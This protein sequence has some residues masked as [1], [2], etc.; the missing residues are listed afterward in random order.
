MSKLRS[1]FARSTSAVAGNSKTW[2]HK[3]RRLIGL[4]LFAIFCAVLLMVALVPPSVS[5]QGG[6]I[7]PRGGVVAESTPSPLTAPLKVEPA[8]L[9]ELLTE[10]G[11]R[12]FLVYLRGEPLSLRPAAKRTVSSTAAVVEAL[13]SR[14]ERSFATLAP[15]VE[16]LSREGHLRESHLLWLPNALAVS[17]DLHALQSLASRPE[18]RLIRADRVIRINEDDAAPTL[19][20]PGEITWNISRIQADRAWNA[21]GITGEGV[22]VA[23]V[24]TG[25]DWLHPALQEAYRGYDPK[26][27]HRH[28]GNWYDATGEGA[29]YPVDA[30]GHGTHVMGIIVGQDGIGVA[31]GAK[32]IAVRAFNSQ[33]LGYASWIHRAFEWILAPEGDPSLAPDVVNNSWGS[34]STGSQEFREDLRAL[35]AAGILPV[36]AAGNSGPYSRTVDSPASLPEALAVGATDADDEVA[37]FS[38]RGPSPWGEVKPEVAAP[39]V[40][41]LSAIPGGA[42]GTKSGTS[43]AAPHAAGVVAL[44]LQADPS[45]TITETEGILTRTATPLGEQTPNNDAGWGL[46]NAYRAAVVASSAGFVSGTVRGE[47]GRPIAWARVTAT[48]YEGGVPVATDVSSDGRYSIALAAGDYALEVTAFGYEPE[49]VSRVRVITGQASV[50]DFSL[51]PLPR[52]YVR[53]TVYE[54]GTG[55]PLSATVRVLDTPVAAATDPD[56]GGYSLELPTGTYTFGVYAWEHRI[57]LARNVPVTA[58]QA[59]TLDF[60][61]EPAPSILVVD[62]GAWYYGSQIHYFEDALNALGYPYHLIRIKNPYED[63]PVFTT[64]M[65]YD[66]V[67]W[68][69]PLDSPG[70]VGAWGA[71]AAYLN[72]GGRLFLTGQDVAFWDDGGSGTFYAPELREYTKAKLA[73]DES[74][75]RGIVGIEGTLFDGLSFDIAGGDGADNQLYP[76]AIEVAEPDFAVL[77]LRYD[78][79][80]IAAVGAFRCL[81]YRSVFFSF[82][83][84]AIAGR[85]ARIQVMD[86]VLEWLMQPDPAEG[87]E[88]ISPRQTA[89][90]EAGTSVSLTLRIRNIGEAGT[91]ETYTLSVE[92]ADWPTQLSLSSVTLAPCVSATF[93]ATVTIPAGEGL[94]SGEVF[95]VV[96][97]SESN[98]AL[99]AALVLTAKV[100]APILVVDDDRWFDQQPAYREALSAAGVPFDVWDVINDRAGMPPPTGVLT[101]YPAVVWFTGY[102]WY[103]PLSEREEALLVAYLEQGGRL[104][105]SS[106]DFLWAR[107]E[108][109]FWRRHIGLITFTNDFTATAVWGAPGPPLDLPP[110][111]TELHY[112]FRNWSDALE[113]GPSRTLWRG[114]HGLAVGVAATDSVF[115]AFPIEALPLESRTFALEQ[116]LAHL[117]SPLEFTFE[118]YPRAVEA[119][120]VLTYR[121]VV[122]ASAGTGVDFEGVFTL[123]EEVDFGG[124]SQGP[125]AGAASYDSGRHALSWSGSLAAG[126]VAS[127]EFTA[128]LKGGVPARRA[129]LASGE[130]SAGPGWMPPL[131]R[132]VRAYADAPDFSLTAIRVSPASPVVLQAITVSVDITNTGVSD[133]GTVTVTVPSIPWL[134]VDPLSVRLP[135][136]DWSYVFEA[137]GFRAWGP[138]SQTG[139]LS[140]R[141]VPQRTGLNTIPLWV[142]EGLGEL[143]WRGTQIE[144]RPLEVFLPLVLKS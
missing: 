86:R 13:Q 84:E 56:T 87:I 128:T 119:G 125:T 57:G 6:E 120:G 131:R 66:V 33:G 79:G 138:V 44:L 35:R 75:S 58:G 132:Y 5:G 21:L 16:K 54:A 123:P 48:P 38:G 97:V 51:A 14:A 63:V 74:E 8:L 95:T 25:V 82:G 72:A 31:P 52:G 106:Q 80:L 37:Y 11:E 34:G 81:A 99:R 60:A 76:D 104:V 24:D 90:G 88:L 92:D 22:V 42:Y 129:L 45:L 10:G 55:Q 115:C 29:L 2:F 4:V 143:L 111:L 3:A 20:T 107:P 101:L 117:L 64:L 140:F 93:V 7:P 50:V 77:L 114:Q 47:G 36:F 39:G 53:G 41:V 102:D 135:G 142:D 116:A 30:N 19:Y 43:M 110:V 124:I 83:F 68:S 108:S 96:A 137:Q 94:D 49:S 127:V 112:P 18:V 133:V 9:K 103:E 15:V 69:S 46:V 67:I 65:A 12:R 71:I 118:G 32:W 98:P 144:V 26:G 130:V 70:Y 100:H 27:L 105:F 61:L 73:L 122:T 62:G 121:A 40:N 136:P 141:I 89:I 85:E 109:P 126:D 139:E 134:P 59:I 91:V 78:N 113:P 17:G 1:S 23:N 28:R